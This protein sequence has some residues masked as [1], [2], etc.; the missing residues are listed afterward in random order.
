MYHLR[1]ERSILT[2]KIRIWQPER[3]V[4][5]Y[6]HLT[7]NIILTVKTVI[8]PLKTLFSAI[9]RGN[10]SIWVLNKKV[11]LT[12]LKALFD[13]KNRSFDCKKCNF[14]LN[15]HGKELLVTQ[16]FNH[17]CPRMPLG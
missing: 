5:P 10:L 12:A 9:K 14:E 16:F 7:K 6:N 3:L 8:L 15:Q 11:L 4:F 13:S 17:G 1:V 2:W